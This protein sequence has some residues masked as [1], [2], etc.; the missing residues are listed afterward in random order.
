LKSF[1]NA[2]ANKGI[3]NTI[4]YSEHHKIIE[5]LLKRCDSVVACDVNDPA[6]IYGFLV[7][8]RIQGILVLHYGYTKLPFRMLGVLRQMLESTGHD[9]VKGTALYSHQTGI[10]YRLSFKYNLVFHPYMLVNYDD[11]ASQG[12]S[13]LHAPFS[14]RPNPGE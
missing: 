3:E 9:F 5:K 4:Y 8:E 2:N 12:D 13:G 7:Y 6:N 14:S 11:A 10:G 1:R